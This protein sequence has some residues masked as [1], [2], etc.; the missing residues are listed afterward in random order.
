MYISLA[1][2]WPAQGN[3]LT[4]QDVLS[5]TRAT[6]TNNFGAASSLKIEAVEHFAVQLQSTR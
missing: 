1:K 2:C 5:E 3:A 4:A 6:L